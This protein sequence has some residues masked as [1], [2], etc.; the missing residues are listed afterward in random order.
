VRVGDRS[1]DPTFLAGEP[2]AIADRL[3]GFVDLGFS[4]FNLSVSGPAPAEQLER[5]AREV[6]PAVRG[7]A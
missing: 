4:A 6:V 1:D 7:A 3:L 2:D 5:L